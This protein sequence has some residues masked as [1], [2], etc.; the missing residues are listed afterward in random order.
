MLMEIACWNLTS[1]YKFP[2]NKILI[3]ISLCDFSFQFYIGGNAALIGNKIA[4]VFPKVEVCR[5]LKLDV[6]SNLFK[7]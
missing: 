3:Y 6:L 7:K 2:N 4:Q 5:F 1:V